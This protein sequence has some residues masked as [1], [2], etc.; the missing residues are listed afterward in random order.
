MICFDLLA[1]A[2]VMVK[3]CNEIVLVLDR[4]NMLDTRIDLVHTRA[5]VD[6]SIQ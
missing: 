5:Q 2:Y 4:K 1:L 6:S 3:R